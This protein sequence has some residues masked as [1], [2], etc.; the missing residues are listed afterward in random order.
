MAGVGEAAAILQ[1]VQMSF[2]VV[3]SCYTYV[4]SAR[5]APVEITR[6]ISEVNS[7]K[8]ILEYL[9]RLVSDGSNSQSVLALGSLMGPQGPFEASTA[10]LQELAKK[11]KALNEASAVR[12]RLLWPIEASKFEE[13][14]QGL[15]KHKTTFIL[16]LAGNNAH[17]GQKTELGVQEVK[18]SIEDLK[19]EEKRKSVLRWLRDAD[20]TS[21]HRAARKKHEQPETG[22][23][24]LKCE[25]FERWK[26]QGGQILWMHGDPG[27]GKTVLRYCGLF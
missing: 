26:G 12:R 27:M 21:N 17:S 16:A 2:Q 13:I 1:L 25:E 15:E 14:L 18:S 3:N 24:L 10:A 9:Q 22:T 4:Q 20:P 23:W 19:T 8:G 11:L 7:L 6:T 5:N